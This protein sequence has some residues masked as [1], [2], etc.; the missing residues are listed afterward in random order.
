MAKHVAP[1]PAKSVDRVSQEDLNYLQE[2]IAQK[3]AAELVANNFG[4][5][6]A[7][8]HQI[9]PKDQIQAD[10]TIVRGKDEEPTD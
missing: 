4:A 7:K 5:Y 3:S 2:V 10:G 1:A 9:G 6:L 8:K